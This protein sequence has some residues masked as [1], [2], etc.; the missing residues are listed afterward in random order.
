MRYT[1]LFVL[2]VLGTSAFGSHQC[3]NSDITKVDIKNLEIA[4][5][6]QEK[7]KFKSGIATSKID[8]GQ[9]A[10][11]FEYT[12][13]KDEWAEPLPGLKLLVLTINKNHLRGSGNYN[14]FTVLNCENGHVK[15]AWPT[16]AINSLKVTGRKIEYEILGDDHSSQLPGP[17]KRF[18]L[19]WNPTSNGLTKKTQ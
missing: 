16:T 11:E 6:S 7:L 13:E 17:G 2:L 1:A 18:I 12:I 5:D 14:I 10:P 8:E 3:P 4:S 15:V 9:K 19:E